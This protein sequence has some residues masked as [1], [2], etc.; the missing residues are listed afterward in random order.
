MKRLLVLSALFVGLICCYLPVNADLAKDTF[1]KTLKE[2]EDRDDFDIIDGSVNIDDLYSKR[3]K[4]SQSVSPGGNKKG[5]IDMM[6]SVCDQFFNAGYTM[7]GLNFDDAFNA[8][9]DYVTGERTIGDL[10]KDIPASV[11]EDSKMPILA[12]GLGQE[13]LADLLDMLGNLE[14]LADAFEKLPDG[15]NVYKPNIYVYSDEPIDFT[16]R[17]VYD[18]LLIDTIP[19]YTDA[20]NV[21]LSDDKLLVNGSNC[22]YL[23]YE[24]NCDLGW[25]QLNEGYVIQKDCRESEFRNILELYG[26]NEVEICDFIEY[27]NNKLDDKDYIM[28]VQNTDLVDKFML[29]DINGVDFDSYY[30]LWF[31][32]KENIDGEEVENKKLDNIVVSHEGTALIEWGGLIIE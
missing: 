26:F 18:D 22:R 20:W 11:F 23:F 30:R 19:E 32:F 7:S 21:S 2:I 31:V 9:E 16:L 28:Y 27:W 14:S 29:L 4:P 17:F 3:K 12:G 24:S 10:I 6:R 13:W 15:I 8:F 5:T 1:E 25:L